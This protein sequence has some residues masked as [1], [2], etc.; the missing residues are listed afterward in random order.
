MPVF[1]VR[2][3][4]IDYG[5]MDVKLHAV[6]KC[7]DNA[8]LPI[9]VIFSKIYQCIYYNNSAVER[10][11]VDHHRQAVPFLDGRPSMRYMARMSSHYPQWSALFVRANTGLIASWQWKLHMMETGGCEECVRLID[12]TGSTSCL[13]WDILYD[14]VMVSGSESG[15]AN[16]GV[17]PKINKVMSQRGW[18]HRMGLAE[19]KRASAIL[20]WVVFCAL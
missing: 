16:A 15:L 4:M 11:R 20:K 19:T 2:Q 18:E 14:I 7:E 12:V 10:Y 9:C 3:E 5:A 6:W 13:S 8:E 17:I 1:P